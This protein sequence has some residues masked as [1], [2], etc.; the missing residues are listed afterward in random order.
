MKAY[1]SAK[2]AERTG[3]VIYEDED[4]REVEC[5]AVSHGDHGLKWDDVEDLGPVRRFLRKGT[6]SARGF[7]AFA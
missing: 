4:G 7:D 3:T 5:T 2:M 6:T 1:Y